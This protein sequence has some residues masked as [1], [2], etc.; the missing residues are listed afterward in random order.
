M[1]QLQLLASARILCLCKYDLYDDPVFRAHTDNFHRLQ[2]VVSDRLRSQQG[3]EEAIR[4]KVMQKRLRFIQNCELTK[5]VKDILYDI[6]LMY[7]EHS[8]VQI[9]FVMA[10]RLWYRC[11][12][13]LSTL[14][15]VLDDVDKNAGKIEFHHFLSV[16]N[17]VVAADASENDL[18]RSITSSNESLCEVSALKLAVDSIFHIEYI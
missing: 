5:E 9:S 13:R 11:G 3:R 1:L 8:E 10:H 6:F 14:N 18:T 15:D 17:Q 2:V 12:L 4:Q 7:T 16:V